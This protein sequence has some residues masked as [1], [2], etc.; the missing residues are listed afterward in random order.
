MASGEE[1]RSFSC[2]SQ[3]QFIDINALAQKITV[4]SP[5]DGQMASGEWQVSAWRV[6][7]RRSYGTSYLYFVSVH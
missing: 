4:C 7:R 2:V 1:K 3:C 5:C 6:A